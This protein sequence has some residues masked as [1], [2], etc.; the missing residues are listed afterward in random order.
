[1]E[2]KKSIFKRWWFWAIIVVLSIIVYFTD[3]S[4][5]QP[6]K[7]TVVVAN[8]IEPKEKKEP[9]VKKNVEKPKDESKPKDENKEVKTPEDIVKKVI[10]KD[11][12]VEINKNDQNGHLL[13]RF[14][15]SENLTNESTVKGFLVDIRDLLKNLKSD[16]SIQTFTFNVTYSLVDNYG[17]ESEDIVIKAG[18]NRE[19]VDKINFDKFDFNKIPEVAD[20]YWS[21]PA[22]Q[23]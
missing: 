18:F 2:K 9:E 1:M 10:E 5:E 22:V 16:S 3:D 17:N 15:G 20:E 23:Q 8:K 7:E 4:E 13:V 6:S 11:R 19:T 12:I 14:K 21:H